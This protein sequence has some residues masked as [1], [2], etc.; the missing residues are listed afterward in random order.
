MHDSNGSANEQK[1]QKTNQP[2]QQT[3]KKISNK[4]K[5]NHKLEG[6][7][8]IEVS[9]VGVVVGA[10]TTG[11][12]VLSLN[13]GGLQGDQTKWQVRKATKRQQNGVKWW[14]GSGLAI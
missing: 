1:K 7:L 13:F 9:G 2:N 6:L 8:A 5:T 11:V 12:G 4:Q 14:C 3:K 10:A